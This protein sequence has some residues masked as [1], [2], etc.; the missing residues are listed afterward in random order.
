MFC[1]FW[2]SFIIHHRKVAFIFGQSKS[3]KPKNTY[4]PKHIVIK[5]RL[6]SRYKPFFTS[7]ILIYKGGF[8]K[9]SKP[10]FT[11][12]CM[13]LKYTRSSAGW[14]KYP[15]GKKSTYS[16]LRLKHFQGSLINLS[17]FLRNKKEKLTGNPTKYVDFLVQIRLLFFHY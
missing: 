16:S 7:K 14:K 8:K 3:I 13:L 4:S 11:D 5:H 9:Q 15:L 10:A 12:T 6:K 17:A 1:S 2:L